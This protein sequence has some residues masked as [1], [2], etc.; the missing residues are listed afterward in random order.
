MTISVDLTWDTFAL[1]HGI[2]YGLFVPKESRVSR[3]LRA[4][5]VTSAEHPSEDHGGSW[6]TA[7]LGGPLGGLLVCWRVGVGL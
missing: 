7:E 3:D 6:R 4:P 1:P 5:G 2:G